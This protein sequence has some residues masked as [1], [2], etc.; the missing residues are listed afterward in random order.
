MNAF[1]Y[2]SSCSFAVHQSGYLNCRTIRPSRTGPSSSNSGLVSRGNG[3]K[4]LHGIFTGQYIFDSLAPIKPELRAYNHLPAGPL[5][6]VSN[7]TRS[8]FPGRLESGASLTVSLG[9]RYELQQKT[10]RLRRFC[11]ARRRPPGGS[12]GRDGCRTPKTVLRGAG[13]LQ[14]FPIGHT[15]VSERENGINQFAVTSLRT[16]AST[17]PRPHRLAFKL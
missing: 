1:S 5:R 7:S 15:L 9:T 13:C 4:L 3:S 17:H 8:V 6:T 11:A 2:G 10:S 14:A 12:P 16:R